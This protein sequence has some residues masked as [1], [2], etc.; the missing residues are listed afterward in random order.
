M[1][2][3]VRLWLAMVCLSAVA[4]I[5]AA[6]GGGGGGSDSGGGG[7]EE[8]SGKVALEG[9]STVLPISQVAVET[10]KSENSGFN[11]TVG[12]KGTGDGFEAFCSGNT[13]ISD[14]SR[15]IE[16]EEIDACEEGGVEYIELPIGLD[17][18]AVTVNT[19]NDWV[20]DIT[21][22]ELNS[23]WA[24]ESEGKVS[25]WS[26]VNSSWPSNELALYGPGTE[27]GTF[28]FFTEVINGEEGASRSDYQA[29]EDDNILVQGI[30][31]DQN[32]VG[33]FGFAYYEQNQENLKLLKVDGVEPSTESIS[34]GE[35]VLSRPLFIYVNKKKLEDNQ[36][37][38]PFV[39]YYLENVKDFVEQAQYVNLPDSTLAETRTQLEDGTTGTIYNDKGELPGGDIESAL[40]QSK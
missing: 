26:D 13:D 30:S 40:K 6:C 3:S 18:I 33:Y 27:S 9:S 31:G 24:P 19:E 2:R 35:Y 8:V 36:V 1:S 5:V 37:L 16:Q 34:S 21:S 32:G 12:G 14:A 28:D 39:D 38:Q 10:F 11:A 15:P 25:S 17:G 4:L 7:G 29:S 22:D 20:T 23:M